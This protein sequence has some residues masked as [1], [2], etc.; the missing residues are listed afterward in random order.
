[1]EALGGLLI[2]IGVAC[3]GGGLL[4]DSNIGRGTTSQ[5]AVPLW[6]NFRRVGIGAIALGVAAWGLSLLFG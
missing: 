2:I 1:M 3:V 5:S 6:R 4:M